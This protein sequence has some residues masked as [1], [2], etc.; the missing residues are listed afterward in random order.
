[1][2]IVE[3]DLMCS[4]DNFGGNGVGHAGAKGNFQNN[5]ISFGRGERR[6]RFSP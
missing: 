5:G 1:M 4:A 3:P 6:G 2:N